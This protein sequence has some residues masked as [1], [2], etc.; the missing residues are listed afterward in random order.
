MVFALFVP[1][2]SNYGQVIPDE[3]QEYSLGFN[4]GSVFPSVNRPMRPIFELSESSAKTCG[5]ILADI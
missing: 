3:F 4:D 5:S 1:T 2:N